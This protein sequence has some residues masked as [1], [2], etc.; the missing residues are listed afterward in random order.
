[1]D[2]LSLIMQF[3][4]RE[5]ASSPCAQYKFSF[6]CFP[7]QFCLKVPSKIKNQI[8]NYDSILKENSNNILISKKFQQACFLVP[9]PELTEQLSWSFMPHFSDRQNREICYEC[10]SHLQADLCNG[11]GTWKAQI[12]TKQKP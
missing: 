11:T 4:Q 5:Y 1:M 7:K 12:Y 3:H 6:I 8:L 9:L 2:Y 10:T